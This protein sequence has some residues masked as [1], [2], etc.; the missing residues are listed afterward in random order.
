MMNANI[1]NVQENNMKNKG[2]YDRVL[3]LD[4]ETTGLPQRPAPGKGSMFPPSQHRYYD[5]AR[6][7]Q[8]A[9]VILNAD[10]RTVEKANYL[11]RPDGF[12]VPPESTRIHGITHER[13]AAEGVPFQRI[14]RTL[15]EAMGWCDLV[16][17]H[18]LRFDMSVILSECFRHKHY[19][20]VRALC[21][22]PRFDTMWEGKRDLHMAKAPKL[23]ELYAALF[24]RPC[25]QV[26]D[27]LDDAI[28]AS[29]CF[30]KLVRRRRCAGL[31][32]QNVLRPRHLIAKPK[33]LTY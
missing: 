12:T 24:M 8:V 22:V 4:T 5:G 13:A 10:C 14:I 25:H 23:V 9:W 15:V 2:L 19:D 27:A 28:I 7:V 33:R 16:V 6:V 30:A 32:R 17:A 26:H 18:N 3:V 11:V 20:E 1:D 21:S 29:R 31:E